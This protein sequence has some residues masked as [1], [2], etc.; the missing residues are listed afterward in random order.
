MYSNIKLTI[1]YMDIETVY[2]DLYGACIFD[3]VE[4]S[5]GSFKW[6]YCGDG[7]GLP[8]HFISTGSSMSSRFRSDF[9]FSKTG[10]L[11]KWE[12]VNGN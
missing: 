8:E 4:I 1:E 5:F 9:S 2:F 11:A 7:S 6:R 10:F 3:Y 12:E